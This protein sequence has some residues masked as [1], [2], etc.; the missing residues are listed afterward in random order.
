MG[1]KLPIGTFFL[2]KIRLFIPK[3]FYKVLDKQL[4]KVKMVR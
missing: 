4:L 2:K 1:F 3:K